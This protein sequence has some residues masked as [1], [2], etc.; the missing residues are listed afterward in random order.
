MDDNKNHHI[1]EI[2]VFTYLIEGTES[3][4]GSN[5]RRFS[6]CQVLLACSLL[7]RHISVYNLHLPLLLTSK[8]FLPRHLWMSHT[9]IRL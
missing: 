9:Q 8:S 4:L 5:Q 1:H 3:I 2:E 7:L 6:L